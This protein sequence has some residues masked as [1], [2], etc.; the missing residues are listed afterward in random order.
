MN[1]LK[2]EDFGRKICTDPTEKK[3]IPCWVGDNIFN[4][5]FVHTKLFEY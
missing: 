4:D 1:D 2:E 5:I 3:K